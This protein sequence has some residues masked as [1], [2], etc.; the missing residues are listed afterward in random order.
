V[1]DATTNV[2]DTHGLGIYAILT[3]WA[4]IALTIAISAT[5]MTAADLIHGRREERVLHGASAAI[6]L[7]SAVFLVPCAVAISLFTSSATLAAMVWTA[8]A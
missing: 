6:G 4:G 5:V 8:A 1:G 7:E 2:L 3:T